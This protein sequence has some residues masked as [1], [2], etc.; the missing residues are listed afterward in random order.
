MLI[1]HRRQ[2]LDRIGAVISSLNSACATMRSHVGAARQ[3]TRPIDEEAAVL[4]AAK[5]D[6][7]EKRALLDA[8]QQHFVLTD[9]ENAAL[10]GLSLSESSPSSG[11]PG[12]RVSPMDER[13]FSAFARLRRIH[14]DCRV[15]LGGADERLGRDIMERSGRQ[16]DAAYGRLF[17]WTQ[18]SFSASVNPDLDALADGRDPEDPRIEPSVRRGLRVLADRPPLLTACLDTFADARETILT[19]AFWRAMGGESGVAAATT[20]PL[21]YVGDMLAW[22]HAAA[23]SED[24]A[25]E[26]LFVADDGDGDL[27]A[28]MQAGLRAEPWHAEAQAGMVKGIEGSDVGDEVIRPFDWKQA[29]TTLAD[30]DLAGACHAVRQR[31]ELVLHG[32]DVP[33][34]AYR[35]ASLLEFYAGMFGR[36]ARG[37][38]GAGGP[39]GPSSDN[40]TTDSQ[41]LAAT[42]TALARL[43][44]SHLHMI[45]SDAEAAVREDPLAP[46]AAAV[47]SDL[48]VPDYL[49][50]ALETAVA[51]AKVH[52]GAFWGGARSR[53]GEKGGDDAKE[54][55]FTPL[56]R[57][58]LDPFID[59]AWAAMVD[60]RATDGENTATHLLA[61]SNVDH[62][63]SRK[64]GGGD[65]DSG[66]DD[67]DDDDDDDGATSSATAA[68]I[69]ETNITL[70]VRDALAPFPFAAA[71]HLPSSTSFP[72]SLSVASSSTLADA[73]QTAHAHL[74]A[75][76][77]R[78]LRVRSGL[79]VLLRAVR[80]FV[81]R[82]RRQK[83]EKGNSVA[84]TESGGTTDTNESGADRDDSDAD[85]I[86]NLPPINP[87]PVPEALQPPSLATTAATLDDFLASALVDAGE[88]L[89]L[90]RVR[91]AAAVQAALADAV[92]VFVAEFGVVVRVLEGLDR[93]DAE[94]EEKG[95]G[96]GSNQ[97]E[98]RGEGEEA[99]EKEQQVARR[100]VFPRTTGEI[101]VLL[102]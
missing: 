92:A 73:A 94:R 36:L 75:A 48:G 89:G 56:L 66:Y 62:K 28:G 29:L 20:D 17:R 21:R 2:Q 99:E 16:L 100:M 81:V 14:A 6:T 80:P 51:L 38:R 32:V 74:C 13:F 9:D 69:L 91:S 22:L 8:V 59:L 49:A 87:T 12:S 31:I 37:V 98:G 3:E 90:R 54:N 11:S 77:I 55:A 30:R 45:L 64:E 96:N 52:E 67:D 72:P 88:E 44:M 19:E 18:A 42:A 53:E 43:T 50:S 34:M 68:A 10:A 58:A 71:T 82:R 79:G 5:R 27:A 70:A 4:L 26:G 35:L 93:L 7:E 23:V 63:S 97:G 40:T 46:T 76:A 65:D 102:S 83:G 47:P 84:A 15:L 1:D 85:I 78:F 57:R 101:R 25:L 39:A 24:E 95:D 41:G 86:L 33:D 61:K 60:L